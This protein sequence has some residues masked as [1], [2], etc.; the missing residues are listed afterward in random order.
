M[1]QINEAMIQSKTTMKKLLT[2]AVAGICLG[3]WSGTAADVKENWD[4]HCA[5]CHGKDG[6]GKTKM[7]AKLKVVDYTD[8]KVQAK[9]KDDEAIKITKEGKKKGSKT[10]MKPYKTVLS[11]KE[12]KELVAHIRKFAKKA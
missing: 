2:L 5:K 3:A 8:P 11:D 12:I 10:L 7:G 9:F 1:K 4:K 6:K